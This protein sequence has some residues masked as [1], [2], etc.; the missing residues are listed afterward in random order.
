MEDELSNIKRRLAEAESE[1][2]KLRNEVY[3]PEAEDEDDYYNE[4]EIEEREYERLEELAANCKCGA[5]QFSSKHGAVHV[6][7]CCCGAE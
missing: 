6:A 2:S 5:W 1:I 3:L 4:D 7:D